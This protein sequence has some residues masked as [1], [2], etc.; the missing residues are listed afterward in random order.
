M[1]W[2]RQPGGR[3]CAL[4]L[5][6]LE[7]VAENQDSYTDKRVLKTNG[8]RYLAMFYNKSPKL[9]EFFLFLTKTSHAQCSILLSVSDFPRLCRLSEAKAAQQFKVPQNQKMTG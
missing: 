1:Q 6:A 8:K 3:A 5:R 7:R 9:L 2:S 4:S